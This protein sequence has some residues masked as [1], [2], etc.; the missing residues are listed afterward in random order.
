MMK[1]MIGSVM[2]SP[3]QTVAAFV[4][5]YALIAPLHAHAEADV[6]E[7]NG[8][9]LEVG[10]GFEVQRKNAEICSYR[11]GEDAVILLK[12]W[13][14]LSK[15]AIEEFVDDGH[16]PDGMAMANHGELR[17]ISTAG[18]AGYLAKVSGT[19][20]GKAVEGVAGGFVGEKGQGVAVLISSVADK[21]SEFEK[22]ADAVIESIE[23]TE[24]TPR[25]D[26]R[27][28]HGML[29]GTGLSHKESSEHGDTQENYYFCSDGYFYSTSS[30]SRHASGG[31]NTMFGFSNSK[32][33]GEWELKNVQGGTQLVLYYNNGRESRAGI[34]DRNGETWVDGTRYYMIENNRCR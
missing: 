3:Q 34:E 9:K 7:G 5:L 33:S 11:S 30:K 24:Y 6:C 4:V 23:F 2:R 29:S 32:D 27:V 15:D 31:G 8:Y 26:A 14:G 22:Q 25:M 10:S 13:P 16:Y 17:Q 28:W 12:D 21:W 18:G 19:V 1:K 20:R